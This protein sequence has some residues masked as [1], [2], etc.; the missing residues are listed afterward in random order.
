M[1]FIRPSKTISLGFENNSLDYE[2]PQQQQQHSHS[3]EQDTSNM[4]H[5]H[6]TIMEATTNLNELT[7]SSSLTCDERMEQERYD[8]FLSQQASD[9]DDDEEQ[10]P[11]P[12]PQKDD[13]EEEED[14]DDVVVDVVHE[15]QP[16]LPSATADAMETYCN[17]TENIY[18]GSATGKSIA[19]E[20][21]PCECKY[22]PDIDNPDAACGD[23]NYCINRMMFME[24]MVDD[25]PC[26]RYC[27]NRRFQLRQYARVDVIRTDKKGFGLRALTDLPT[28]AFIMEYIGEVIPNHEFIRRTKEYE[29]AGL[30]HYYF[31]TLKTD[32]IIDATK[33][34]C[35]ARFINHSCNPNSVTQKWVVG[36]NMRI[37]IFTRR[38]IK[39]GSELT[40]DYKFERY[41]A[42][43]QKC[44]CGEATCK[45]FI[46][47]SMK[48]DT[49]K[50]SATVSSD[51]ILD[52]DD[53]DEDDDDDD[54][55]DDDPNNDMMQD[56][57]QTQSQKS[58]AEAVTLTQK[59]MLRKMHRR[60]ASEPLQDPRE[61]Q[62]FVKRMLDSVGKSH[63]VLKLL[64]RL[65]LTD[66]DTP[67]GKDVLKKFVRLHGLKMLKF[68]LGEWK[69]DPV[70]LL[71]VL[72]VLSKLPLAN[73]NGLED[74]KM[75]EIVGKLSQHQ[76]EG[77]KSLATQLLIDWS[78]L[79]SVYRIPKRIPTEPTLRRKS[80]ANA[81]CNDDNDSQISADV[82]P[83]RYDSSREFFDPDDD[84]FEYLP[85]DVDAAEIQWKM[86][87]P[88]QSA[89]PTAP[90][91]MI[92]ACIKNGF[93][94]YGG[95]PPRSY[96][97]NEPS[98]S[99]EQQQHEEM[100][101]PYKNKYDSPFNASSPAASVS[102]TSVSQIPTKPAGQISPKLPNNWK[103]A[104]AEDGA[105]YYYHRIT[106]KTQWQ[107]PEE[108]VSSIE[109]VNQSDLED[110]VEKTIQETEN[111]KKKR[112]AS[113]AGS[114]T[115]ASTPRIITPSASRKGSPAVSS[116]D[117]TEL[118]KEVGKIV[119]KY[120]SSKQKKLW[121]GDKH[122]FKELARKT[123]HHIVEREMNSNRKIQ[124]MNSSVKSKIEKFIDAHGAEFVIKVQRKMKSSK[125]KSTESPS[126]VISEKMAT[127]M[128]VD[129]PTSP[130]STKHEASPPQDPPPSLPLR[131]TNTNTNTN[132]DMPCTN[133]AAAATTTNSAITTAA[134]TKP[135]SP[136]PTTTANAAT[137][138]TTT[139]ADYHVEGNN[140]KPKEDVYYR[141][142]NGNR[143]PPPYRYEYVRPGYTRPS[144][145]YHSNSYYRYARPPSPYYRSNRYRRSP[146]PPFYRQNSSRRGSLSDDEMDRRRWD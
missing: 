58:M 6:E 52:Q 87:Y 27:R 122:L 48:S 55:D 33:K 74:C 104:Y 68:W 61:V 134:A 83:P 144:P 20:S 96:S 41:G 71:K 21:M 44:Y 141:R 101:N 113:P 128:E 37:G 34:G 92:D 115:T 30:E 16:Q 130:V 116:L 42:V 108:R 11:P 35:L 54:D 94:G 50:S 99:V 109:G 36:K 107:V 7:L 75:L 2:L 119:T 114:V 38:P 118:K 85:M 129:I 59:K 57:G 88:P 110:L 142:S 124:S 17:I 70:I 67:Q 77:I 62:S 49:A 43:A 76:D 26:D 46:G 53:E 66:S 98:S 102:T 28:N 32:E 24:C 1:L 4:V 100:Y 64:L 39:A 69:S 146:P 131:S 80:E 140:S 73:R 25:C 139:S 132:T 103:S 56:E 12:S 40:F 10:P 9:S 125:G 78:L 65:E 145:Y 120:L 18:C 133:T 63:L 13:D 14:D 86:E 89:I 23:D 90:K 121:N 97:H 143:S 60:R 79:K 8:S 15:E 112:S 111:K 127:P 105:I 123:T 72:Q 95:R 126:S 31:M 3:Q 106:G 22:R 136:A 29:A 81:K 51:L 93:Y 117:E 138:S 19:E 84:Y 137:T 91:A 82:P 47:G 5:G 45:G 135:A